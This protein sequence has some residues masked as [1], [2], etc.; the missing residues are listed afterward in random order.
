MTGQLDS[1]GDS[2]GWGLVE[3]DW[4]AEKRWQGENHSR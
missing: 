2:R 1:Q 3:K 4:V